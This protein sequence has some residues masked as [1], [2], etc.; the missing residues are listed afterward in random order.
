MSLT[1]TIAML[2]FRNGMEVTNLREL[3]LLHYRRQQFMMD[4]IDRCKDQTLKL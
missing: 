3:G 4:D 1:V 2:V